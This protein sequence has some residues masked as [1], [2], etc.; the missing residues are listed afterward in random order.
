MVNAIAHDDTVGT[1][2]QRVMVLTHLLDG[3]EHEEV[4]VVSDATHDSGVV[5]QER[6]RVNKLAAVPTSSSIMFWAT[7]EAN[8]HDLLRELPVSA[9]AKDFW[10]LWYKI[11]SHVVV[12]SADLVYL[13]V[14]TLDT[15][16]TWV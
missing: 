7:A 10:R 1:H 2:P 11:F 13:L 5:W 8:A 9:V 6:D 16:E 12:R 15:E 3:D 4:A 14:E